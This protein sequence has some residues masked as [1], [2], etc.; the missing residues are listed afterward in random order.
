MSEKK[1]KKAILKPKKEKVAIAAQ[2]DVNN[3]INEKVKNL[4]EEKVQANLN[5]QKL[6]QDKE[7]L[8]KQIAVLKKDVN[9]LEIEIDRLRSVI[10]VDNYRHD[11]LIAEVYNRGFWAR[12]WNKKL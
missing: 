4:E 7:I 3:S 11:E 9:N 8:S 6:E 12:V 1:T 5:A 2:K 10:Y